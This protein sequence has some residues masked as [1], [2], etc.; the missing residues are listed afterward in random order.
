M[1]PIVSFVGQS[2]SGKTML[3]EKVVRELKIR[4]Y[5][6]A[7]IKHS[8]H[9]FEIDKPGK[10]TWRLA[11][12]GSDIV[13]ISSMNKMAFIERM[14]TEPTLTQIEALFGGK[15]DIVLAE[16]YKNGNTAKIRI[17]GTEENQERLCS[18]EG[19]LATVSARLS[20]L[21]VP[22]FDYDDIISI[23]NLL[24]EQVGE[25]SPHIFR[26]VFKAT[27]LIPGCSAYQMAKFEGLLAESAA[28]H[29]HICPGQVLGVRMAMR[30]CH[31]LGIEKPKEKDKR[32]VAYVE[33][34]RCAID[35]IQVVT[36]CKM[37]KRT[38]KYV[39]YGKLAATFVDL[40]TEKAVRIVAREDA[41]EKAILWYR[42]EW[43]RQE[44]EIVAYRAM[45]DEELFN[46]EHVLV[47]IPV[48][49]MPGPPLRRVIC[50]EC[51]EGVNDSREVMVAGQVLCRSC[52]YGRY[53]Q[54]LGT[55]GIANDTS[56][57]GHYNK[58]PSFLNE[59]I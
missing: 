42:P 14:D 24:I 19:T 3:L 55:S 29:G 32:L 13:A 6:V 28:L 50:D 59:E 25:K 44:A 56:L 58:Q 1:M 21:G 35:A 34:D 2:N 54:R 38:M 51:G 57:T 40:D 23:A 10:D 17:L 27:D 8:P 7:V 26:D 36:G 37:G 39:D 22:Q 9:G 12:A 31:E 43:T 45:S 53:Y 30:G 18:E 46:I 5:R 33:I 16:G 20:S 15:V 49:D 41:R 48:E 4:G 47:Q 11:Q 52:A